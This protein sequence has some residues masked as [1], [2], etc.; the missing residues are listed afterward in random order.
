MYTTTITKSGQI[1]L[2]KAAREKLGVKPGDKVYVD[3]ENNKL[4]VE[5][6]ASAEELLAELD[7][8]GN[9]TAKDDAKLVNNL[10]KR[11]DLSEYERLYYYKFTPAY[12]YEQRPETPR[13]K[14]IEAAIAEHHKL[15]EKVKADY[16]KKGIPFNHEQFE[17]I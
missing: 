2:T 14:E 16:K 7:K 1:T 4:A 9:R 11:E 6:Q 13:P 10:S 12:Y 5:K 3:F 17:A 15:L 8:I